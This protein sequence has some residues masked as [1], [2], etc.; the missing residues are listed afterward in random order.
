MSE[1]YSSRARQWTETKCAA[2]P[3]GTG[4]HFIAAPSPVNTPGEAAA[5][6]SGVN[7]PHQSADRCGCVPQTGPEHVEAAGADSC[8]RLPP[9]CSVSIREYDISCGGLVLAPRSRKGMRLGQPVW[10]QAQS[11]SV[12]TSPP[13]REPRD[14]GHEL[15]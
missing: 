15:G 14:R 8:A 6:A 3:G 5:A 12:R 1:R 10:S 7:D 13:R 9:Y 11:D 2:S 4:R